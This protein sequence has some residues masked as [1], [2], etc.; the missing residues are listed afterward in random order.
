MHFCSARVLHVRSADDT[1]TAATSSASVRPR[2]LIIRCGAMALEVADL[3][4]GRWSST[5]HHPLE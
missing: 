4:L 1:A 3:D 2:L 5:T